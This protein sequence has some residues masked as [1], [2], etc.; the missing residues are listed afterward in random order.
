[1]WYADDGQY[2][3]YKLLGCDTSVSKIEEYSRGGYSETSV[4]A[5]RPR[6]VKPYKT[7]VI[8]ESLSLRISHCLSQGESD[9]GKTE[10]EP[11]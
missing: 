11:T 2:E 8:N 9:A 4:S 5:V 3:V 6:V 1:M 7:I 10:R